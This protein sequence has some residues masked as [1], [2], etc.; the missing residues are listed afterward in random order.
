MPGANLTLL[1]NVNYDSDT[2]TMIDTN[3]NSLVAR[4]PVGRYPQEITW[5][6]DG[7]FVYVANNTANTVSVIDAQSM[8]VT[9]TLPTPPGPTAI[10]VTPDGR[11]GYVTCTTGGV[12]AVL[13]LSA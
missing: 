4:I 11:T 8:R 3:T 2:V 1:A 12:V 7:R 9:A 10:A 6:P 13:N 5:A